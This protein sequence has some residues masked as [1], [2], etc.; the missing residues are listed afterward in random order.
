MSTTKRQNYGNQ[1]TLVASNPGGTVK[2]IRVSQLDEVDIN[3][4]PWL[5]T[6]S[7]RVN[8]VTNVGAFGTPVAKASFGSGGISHNVTFDC[9]PDTLIAL[10]GTSVDVDIVWDD[11]FTQG[12][13]NV[14]IPT[15]PTSSQLP[16]S[17][18]IK[19]SCKQGIPSLP[20]ASRTMFFAI[21][22]ALPV[23]FE[24]PAFSQEFMLYLA[25]EAD[26]ADP[27]CL[28]TF[29]A[30]PVGAF[31]ITTVTGAALKAIKDAGQFYQIPG[32]ATNAVMTTPGESNPRA[33]FGLNL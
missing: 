28:V 3:H 23:K 32:T 15:R 29:N 5:V 16:D 24:I 1:G 21:N 26:Y 27:G 17:A 20:N 6:C 9:R 12:T 33:M 7:S 11:V 10:P 8:N 19:A 30:D 13:G 4:W 14:A 22:A 2:L 31:P 18:I 25:V